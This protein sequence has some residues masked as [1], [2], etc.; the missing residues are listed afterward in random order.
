LTWTEEWQCEVGNTCL[1]GVFSFLPC[2]PSVILP[3]HV[4]SLTSIIP[5]KAE[6]SSSLPR[7]QC[8][9]NTGPILA[10]V[11]TWAQCMYIAIRPFPSPSHPHLHLHTYIHAYIF[12]QRSLVSNLRNSKIIGG[13]QGFAGSTLC[14]PYWSCVVANPWFSTCVADAGYV[15]PPSTTPDLAPPGAFCK[16]SLLFT[17]PLYTLT[18]SPKGRVY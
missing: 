16:S 6:P 4:S 7:Y 17:S 11:F 12:L 18:R 10:H 1:P 5:L 2:L 15:V 3:P 14:P 8:L 9:P 13:G